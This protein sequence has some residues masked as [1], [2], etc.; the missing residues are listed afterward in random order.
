M[1]VWLPLRAMTW[2]RG[3]PRLVIFLPLAKLL[4]FCYKENRLVTLLR[5]EAGNTT[6]DTVIQVCIWLGLFMHI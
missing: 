4:I 3:S 5:I 1:V 6:Y 2:T